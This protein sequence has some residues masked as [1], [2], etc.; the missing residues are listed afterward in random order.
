MDANNKNGAHKNVCAYELRTKNVRM[1]ENRLLT[2]AVFCSERYIAIARG[3]MASGGGYVELSESEWRALPA[4]YSH[5]AHVML[6]AQWPG[7]FLGKYD[8]RYAVSV[9]AC[10]VAIL[11]CLSGRD[12]ADAAS[13]RRHAGIS[14]RAGGPRGDR[15]GG[16]EQGTERGIT[17]VMSVS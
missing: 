2:L 17:M 5:A 13:L 14:R 12:A 3:N 4:T 16:G 9:S 8:Y 15:R 10:A 1:S 6:Y 11:P 7:R